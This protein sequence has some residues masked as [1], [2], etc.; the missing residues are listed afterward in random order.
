M[1]VNNPGPCKRPGCPNPC[2]VRVGKHN[3]KSVAR[4]CSEECRKANYTNTHPNGE[5]YVC[6]HCG[7]KGRRNPS[8]LRRRKHA[9]C[10]VECKLAASTLPTTRL[11]EAQQKE[12]LDYR[13]TAYYWATRYVQMWP[14]H[15]ETDDLA[16][17]GWGA[18]VIAVAKGQKNRTLAAKSA[19]LRHIREQAQREWR[20]KRHAESMFV[21]IEDM[22]GTDEELVL[23]GYFT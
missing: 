12:V 7:A 2:E 8:R 21:G 20:T 17:I 22:T 10:S 16:G 5:E 4:Y 13:K 6:A 19:I 23:G 3:R 1:S 15:F 14:G 11:T 9:H 18:I